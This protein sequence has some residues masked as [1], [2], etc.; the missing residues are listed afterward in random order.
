MRPQSIRTLLIDDEVLARLA[1]RQALAPHPEVEIVGECG[2]ADEA[3]QAIRLLHPDLLILDIQMPGSDGFALL[4]KLSS[5]LPMI[6][7]AT[8]FDVHAMRAFDA[9]ALDYLLK[10]LDQARVDRTMERVKAQWRGGQ[11]ISN[12]AVRK[13][14]VP[15]TAFLTRLSVRVGEYM[16][17]LRVD[18]ID[19]IGAEG[20]YVHIHVGKNDLLHRET[21]A[22]LE[23]LL[24]PAQFV[25]IH[26]GTLVNMDRIKEI[27]PLFHGGSKIVLQDG[28]RL[29][30]SRRF[31]DRIR[32]AVGAR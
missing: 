21:L 31:R 22:N 8:A 28:N 16:R 30:L 15:P 3:L 2:N 29:A 10:P 1:L 4:R 19:W 20:N 11:A 32:S 17:V 14:L 27:H 23:S 24:D 9:H 26:R 13:L 6:V 12:D 18:E 25:R 5:E 7:F